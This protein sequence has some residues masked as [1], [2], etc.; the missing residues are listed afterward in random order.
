M[1]KK[2]NCLYLFKVLFVLMNF[3]CSCI[4]DVVK[5]CW[6]SRNWRFFAQDFMHQTLTFTWESI[7]F[8]QK[9]CVKHCLAQ[10]NM[11]K[12]NMQAH[13]SDGFAQMHCKCSWFLGLN[14]NPVPH[15]F[16][17]CICSR[18]KRAWAISHNNSGDEIHFIVSRSSA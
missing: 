10:S 2:V 8:Y 3:S 1:K 5:R 6:T 16:S 13:C 11:H 9:R 7:L 17:L 12:S 15:T 4:A 18:N 14:F